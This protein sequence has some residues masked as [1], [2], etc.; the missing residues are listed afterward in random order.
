MGNNRRKHHKPAKQT[1]NPAPLSETIPKNNA[2]DTE[3]SPGQ[4]DNKINKIESGMLRWTRIVGVFTAVLAV[5]GSLQWWSFVRSERPFLGVSG[6]YIVG[7][8]FKPGEPVAFV[9]EIQ[10]AGKSTAYI[11]NSAILFRLQGHPSLDSGLDTTFE[12]TGASGP[13]LAGSTIRII[14]RPVENHAPVILTQ[15]EI[16]RLNNRNGYLWVIGKISYSDELWFPGGNTTFG[17]CFSYAH[18]TQRSGLSN[19]VR[20]GN[21]EYEYAN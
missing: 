4:R 11:T 14:S 8:E 7:N 2:P 9:I 5:V 20:C 12:K 1:H 18:V 15:D 21:S 10:N 17:Y 19:F 6:I 13:V 3:Q 16:N